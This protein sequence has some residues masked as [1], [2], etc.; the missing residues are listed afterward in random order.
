MKKL[1]RSCFSRPSMQS[2]GFLMTG[3]FK[4]WPALVASLALLVTPLRA[5]FVYV[6]SESFFNNIWA[7]SIGSNGTLTPVPGSPFAGGAEPFSVAVDPTAKFVY[8]ANYF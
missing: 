5:Q 7:Y 8:V 1:Y 6:G 4:L 3:N 2:V